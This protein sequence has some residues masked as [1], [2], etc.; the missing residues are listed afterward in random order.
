MSYK[1][2]MRFFMIVAQNEVFTLFKITMKESHADPQSTVFMIFVS[3][4]PR[5]DDD[6][7]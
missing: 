1:I 6:A 5:R 7:A 2:S 4:F 3:D